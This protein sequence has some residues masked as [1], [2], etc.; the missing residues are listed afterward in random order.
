MA[1]NLN[2]LAFGATSAICHSLLKLYAAK[3]A[4]IFLVGRSADSLAALGDDLSVRGATIAGSA[5]YDF[6][7]G[8]RHQQTVEDAAAALGS[9][10]IVVVAHGSLPEQSECE[11][12]GAAVKACMDDNF[13]SAAVIAQASA[14]YFDQQQRGTLAIISSVAGDRGRKSNYTYG[15][16]KAGLDALIQGLQGRFAG[17]LVKVVNIKPG[18]VSSPMTQHLPQGPLFASPEGIAPRIEAAIARG[19]KVCYV[20]GYWRLIMLVIRL[21]PTAVLA[22]LP[23]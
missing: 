4:A 17:S 8:E 19:S 15:A 9:I 10:D 11:S 3:G 1:N 16:A 21:L 12:S 13:T 5:C 23:I 14:A 22:R 2:I 18:M 6:N 7:S 20:P